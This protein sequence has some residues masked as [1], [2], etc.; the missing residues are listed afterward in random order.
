MNVAPT[1]K[2][3]AAPVS[4]IRGLTNSR[5][6]DPTGPSHDRP[7]EDRDEARFPMRQR[8]AHCIG[9]SPCEPMPR[10]PAFLALASVSCFLA[11]WP[12]RNTL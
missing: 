5:R 8:R 1:V 9:F 12:R 11:L 4:S 2:I 3:T 10:V 7:G 6:P